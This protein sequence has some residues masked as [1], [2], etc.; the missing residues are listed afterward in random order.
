M[1]LNQGPIFNKNQVHFALYNSAAKQVY[2]KNSGLIIFL[3]IPLIRRR[4]KIQ[5]PV[6]AFASIEN[7]T[8][9]QRWYSANRI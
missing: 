7:Y 4:I 9:K 5:F 8:T 1:Q 2:F 3:A 6:V